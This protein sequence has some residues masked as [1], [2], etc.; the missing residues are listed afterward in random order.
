M[1]GSLLGEEIRVQCERA[2]EDKGDIRKL[3][4]PELK[5]E[6]DDYTNIINWSK[7]VVT[8]PP[9]TRTLSVNIFQKSMESC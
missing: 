6:S 2:A 9:I 3:G 7:V 4:V 1:S 5:L 8:E